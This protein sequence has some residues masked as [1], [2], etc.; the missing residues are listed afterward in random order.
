MRKVAGLKM[1]EGGKS[2]D[3]GGKKEEN[4]RGGKKKKEENKRLHF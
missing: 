1:K 2:W 3:R 4:N